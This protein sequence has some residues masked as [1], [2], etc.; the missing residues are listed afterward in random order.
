M[1]YI[2]DANDSMDRTYV[3]FWWFMRTACTLGLR[4]HAHHGSRILDNQDSSWTSNSKLLL[5]TAQKRFGHESEAKNSEEGESYQS[6]QP[7]SLLN[8]MMLEESAAIR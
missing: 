2:D 4:D 7:K 3:I 8:V 6:S 1:K 5:R